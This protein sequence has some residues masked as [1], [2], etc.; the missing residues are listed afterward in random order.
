MEHYR[1][2]QRPSAIEAW[3]VPENRYYSIICKQLNKRKK[4]ASENNQSSVFVKVVYFLIVCLFSI[5][6][7]SVVCSVPDM[8]ESVARGLKL[9]ARAMSSSELLT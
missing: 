2:R 9:S 6:W 5:S 7:I 4:K 1:I 8:K 3:N